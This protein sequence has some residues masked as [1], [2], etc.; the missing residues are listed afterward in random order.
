MKPSILIIDDEEELLGF[1]CEILQD[2]YVI[3]KASNAEAGLAILNAHQP[4]LI[5]SDIM[6]PGLN[7]LELCKLLKDDASLYHIPVILLTARKSDNDKLEGLETGADA[8]MCK[9]FSPR[10]LQVQVNNLIKNRTKIRDHVVK[11]PLDESLY[12]LGSK[13]DESFLRE[14]SQYIVLN[15]DNKNLGVDDLADHMNMSRPT[16]YRR[17]K[18]ASKLSPKDFI[19]RIRVKKAAELIAENES[20]FFQIA[21]KVGFN[22][23]SVFGRNFQKHFQSSPKKFL[24]HL[25]SKWKD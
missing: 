13:S 21:D 5:I 7:G 25:K 10:M 18:S 12:T 4:D 15:I 3:H 8:Y 16:F 22:S 14:V 20:K 2:T 11:R 1:L 24:D 23:Q 9:P 6:M 19:D 17:M